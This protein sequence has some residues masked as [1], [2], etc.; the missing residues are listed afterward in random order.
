MKNINLCFYYDHVIIVT[1]NISP[2]LLFISG[3]T[4]LRKSFVLFVHVTSNLT[5]LHFNVFTVSGWSSICTK[6]YW[7]HTCV[8]Y[9]DCHTLNSLTV[10]ALASFAA[11]YQVINRRARA[12]EDV[13]LTIKSEKELFSDY[14]VRWTSSIALALLLITWYDAANKGFSQ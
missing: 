14:I 6:Y 9:S 3:S 12:T 4:L 13:H 8:T 7:S 2:S 5:F 1:Y 11:S 10:H